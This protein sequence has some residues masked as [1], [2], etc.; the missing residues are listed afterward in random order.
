MWRSLPSSQMLLWNGHQFNKKLKTVNWHGPLSPSFS[1]T[2]VSSAS[3]GV[4]V[5]CRTYKWVYEFLQEQDWIKL[6]PN[7]I[8]EDKLFQ[9]R[10]KFLDCAQLS[11]RSLWAWHYCFSTTGSVKSQKKWKQEENGEARRVKC[12]LD[13]QGKESV[14]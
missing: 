12:L 5:C 1:I 10:F 11:M 14:K 2:W 13:I 4:N 8:A 6:V 9:I 3:S 7:S